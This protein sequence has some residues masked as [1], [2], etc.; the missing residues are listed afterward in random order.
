MGEMLY[1][2]FLGKP[3]PRVP[4]SVH[5]SKPLNKMT[6]L[7]LDPHLSMMKNWSKGGRKGIIVSA[8]AIINHLHVL[9]YFAQ[10]PLQY[11]LV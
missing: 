3:G 10:D 4:R 6:I 11:S 7:L 8:G 9:K 5:H 2:S 1:L